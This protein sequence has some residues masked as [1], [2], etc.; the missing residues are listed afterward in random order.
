MPNSPTGQETDPILLKLIKNT[1]QHRFSG[2]GLDLGQAARKGLEDHEILYKDV[3]AIHMLTR[4]GMKDLASSLLTR[5]LGGRKRLNV[6][7][8]RFVYRDDTAG[9]VTAPANPIHP[10]WSAGK[11]TGSWSCPLGSPGLLVGSCWALVICC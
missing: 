3:S 7:Q 2:P 6:L 9:L 4:S 5:A 1:A 10:E 8:N 11:R